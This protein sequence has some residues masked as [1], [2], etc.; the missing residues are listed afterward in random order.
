M[1]IIL[2]VFTNVLLMT[3]IKDFNPCIS[4]IAI[5]ISIEVLLTFP[6]VN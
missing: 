5:L 1:H 4:I 3:N 6:L 2:V